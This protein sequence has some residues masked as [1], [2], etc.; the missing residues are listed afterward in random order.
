MIDS[1]RLANMFHKHDG[2]SRKTITDHRSKCGMF[3]R[4][5]V[6]DMDFN[7]Q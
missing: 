1:D 6:D 2:V 4:C 3:V 5:H 7:I